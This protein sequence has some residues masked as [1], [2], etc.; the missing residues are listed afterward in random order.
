MEND[1]TQRAIITE[2]DIKKL[3]DHYEAIQKNF[4]EQFE[5]IDQKRDEMCSQRRELD[6]HEELMFMASD[7]KHL[8]FKLHLNS[9]K[10]STQSKADLLMLE[11]EIKLG[12]ANAILKS[13]GF[14]TTTDDLRKAALSSMPQMT[15]LR[16]AIGAISAYAETLVNLVQNLQADE[17]NFRRSTERRERLGG[18]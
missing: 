10:I 12:K 5:M 9:L 1:N 8:A 7:L 17:V 18:L 2:A 3:A 15:R 14:S 6:D 11:G 16:K 13:Y 4:D